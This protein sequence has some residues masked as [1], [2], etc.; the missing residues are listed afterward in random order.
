MTRYRSTLLLVNQNTK[1]I[2]NLLEAD[3]KKPELGPEEI[4]RS[5][6]RRLQGTKNAMTQLTKTAANCLSILQAE[7]DYYESLLACMT[8]AIERQPLNSL[9]RH[10]FLPY[11]ANK[12]SSLIVP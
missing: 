12:K 9:S 3:Q 11:F 5:K 8:Q 4:Y 10:F 1:I 7:K 2:Y 6:I